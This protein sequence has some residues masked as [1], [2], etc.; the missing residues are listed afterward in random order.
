MSPLSA[1]LLDMLALEAT[2]VEVGYEPRRGD[3]EVES[4]AMLGVGVIWGP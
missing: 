4:F 3:G 1:D 2:T